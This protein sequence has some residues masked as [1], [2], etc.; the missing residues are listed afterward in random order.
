MK[1]KEIVI[2]SSRLFAINNFLDDLIYSLKKQYNITIISQIDGQSTKNHKIKYININFDRKINLFKDFFDVFYFFFYLRKNNPDLIITITPKISFLVSLS[3]FFFRKKRIH[4]F[5]GQIWYNYS[6]VKKIIFK[7]FDKFILS[8][9]V[10]AFVDSKSQIKYLINNGFKKNKLKLINNGSICGVDTKKFLSNNKI[11][12]RFKRK[13]RIKKESII[14]LYCGRITKDKG[15]FDLLNLNQKLLTDKIDFNLV[16]A[17]SDEESIIKKFYKSN[18][19]SFENF[20]FLDYVKDINKILPVADIFIILSKREGFGMSVIEAS[21]CKIPIIATNI[22]GLRDSVVNNYT[23][24]LIKNYQITRDYNR[25]LNMFNSYNVRK[26]FGHN[27]RIY[28]KNFYEK[29]NVI[30]FLYKEI[31]NLIK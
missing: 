11:K 9:S 14:L 6:N 18:K 15:F 24:I 17:G 4:F 29:K 2:F 16:V 20:I 3:N 10:F 7:N 12:Q 21:S 8:G 30:N 28:V 5:T 13:Y 23:G 27:G 19:Y 1:K 25:I 22:V 31:T 26:K